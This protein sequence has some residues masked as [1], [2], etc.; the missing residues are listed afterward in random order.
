MRSI[1]CSTGSVVVPSAKF[2]LVC[3]S[4]REWR[5]LTDYNLVTDVTTDEELA[6]KLEHVSIDP[7]LLRE[8]VDFYESLA[9]GA[10]IPTIY[11]FGWECEYRAMIFDLLGPSLEDLFNYCDR[12]FSLKTVL[13]IADQLI[14]RLQYIHSK[15]VIHRDIKAENFL[16]GTGKN[17]N[18]IYI[19][20]LG[21]A[22]TY[23]PNREHVGAH[24]SSP[25]LLGTACLASIH[26][27]L[28]I[29][30]LL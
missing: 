12:Q 20:D 18:C 3:Y 25:R 1:V 13:M 27:H 22:A 30:K 29:G 19:T 28:G 17:G 16:M 15:D 23:R 6:I 8:E 7:S 9:G 11:W 24:P 4:R 10:G 5:I 2:I 14:C 21:L 26:G